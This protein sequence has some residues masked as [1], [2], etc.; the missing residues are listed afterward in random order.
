MKTI[1]A[2]TFVSA[3]ALAVSATFAQAANTDAT[4]DVCVAAIGVACETPDAGP[5]STGGTV[6]GGASH[7]E[8]DQDD[9]PSG[10]DDD[11]NGGND[12]DDGNDH[13]DHDGGNDHDDDHGDDHDDDN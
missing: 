10:S 9:S 5:S 12:D 3:L 1:L 11:H 13:G 7:A 8:D 2:P 6:S 4:P